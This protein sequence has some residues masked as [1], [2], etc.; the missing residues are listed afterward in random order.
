MADNF[1][2][3]TSISTPS[4][5]SPIMRSVGA[6]ITSVSS[7][8]V[9]VNDGI[10]T[11]I[12]GRIAALSDFTQLCPCSTHPQCLTLTVT[13]LSVLFLIFMYAQWCEFNFRYYRLHK[14]RLGKYVWDSDSVEKEGE[15]LRPVWSPDAKNACPATFSEAVESLSL[16][17]S[18]HPLIASDLQILAVGCKGGEVEL[19]SVDET[20]SVSCIAWTPGYTAF[21]V[22][23]KNRGLAVWY[24]FLFYPRYIPSRPKLFTL[25]FDV[26]IF[27]VKILGELSPVE[28]PFMK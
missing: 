9:V 25:P 12:S 27:H 16:M 22:G 20:G 6:S 4:P 24:D 18:M 23:W 2:S 17:L 19:Y 13:F 7:V 21:A 28:K 8:S 10:F 26:H 11:C 1:T 3:S 15:N 14:V 5:V